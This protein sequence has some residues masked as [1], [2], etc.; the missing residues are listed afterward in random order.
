MNQQIER[1][2]I[3]IVDDEKSNIIEL[4]H[5]L[6]DDYETYIV[7]D[8][9]E[10]ME[11]AEQVMPDVILLDILMPE[12]DGY[13][14]L[15]KLKESEKTNNI[16][17][18]F[19]TGLNSA[20]AE[21]KG[22]SLGAADYITKPFHNAIVKMRIKNQMKIIERYAIE[23]HEKM[24]QAVND[25]ANHL[26]Q[27]GGSDDVLPSLMKG[28]EV[29]CKSMNAD[30]FNIWRT[31]MKDG[32]L[33]YHREYSWFS[34][35][36]SKPGETPDVLIN[37]TGEDNLDWGERFARDETISGIISEM[38][39]NDKKFLSV[40]G[41]KSV[42]ICPLFLHGKFWGI[43]SLDDCTNERSFRENEINVLKSIS[44]MMVSAL[45][46][47]A[48]S[49]GVANT[50]STMESILDSIGVAIYATVPDTGELLFV[51][52]YMKNAFGIVGDEA[53]GKH[54]YEVFRQGYDKMCDFCPCYQL[55]E[56]PDATIVWDEYIPA[57]DAH[58]RHSDC[59]INWYD[60]RKVHMQYA[61]D[62]TQLTKS[63]EEA[64]AASKAKSEFL[65]NMSHEIRTP[66]NAIFGMT[67]IG[68]KAKDIDKKDFSF[69]KI[70][71]ASSHLLGIINDI[72]DIAKIEA[73][74]MEIATVEFDFKDM[75]NKIL[76]VTNVSSDEKKQIVTVNVDEKI[77]AAVIG[78]DKRLTQVITNLLSNAIKFTDEG[79]KIGLNVSIEGNTEKYCELRVEVTD[80][81]I[82][83]SPE[84]LEKLFDAFEQAES[85][86]TRVYGGTGLGLAISKSIVEA[87]GGQIWAESDLG[88]GTKF[89]FIIRVAHSMAHSADEA[90]SQAEESKAEDNNAAE[91]QNAT[92]EGKRLLIVEDMASNRFVLISLLE[93]SGLIIDCAVNGKEALDMFTAD[94]DKYDIIFMDIR[95]P[96]MDGHEATRKIRA[97]DVPKAKKIPIIAVTANVFTEDIK[98]CLEAGMDG[99]LRKPVEIDGVMEVLEKYLLNS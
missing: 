57:M 58:V 82:G 89:T 15:A 71:E 96:I 59:Y 35:E 31:E 78:D 60:G 53:I 3:L 83:I 69:D 72:L 34:E 45:D 49:K 64:Q 47:H 2:K 19:I 14:V 5:I 30:R 33:H 55:N 27:L 18:I 67:A 80:S 39:A 66:M 99:H 23:K 50:L 40:L 91:V 88:S 20:D 43:F 26:F 11:T 87:M 46:R 95:M 94:P 48:L 85:G 42:I 22:L 10:T 12:M 41:I 75:I 54:C 8:S 29:I 32:R 81:G 98:K 62:I 38:P 37:P 86:T 16:P 24:L 1:N 68:K 79:G 17:V 56:N 51:N 61:V 76:T 73:N 77:P 4:T 25:T 70:E 84:N 28:M 90:P 97:L 74:K 44:L 65:A 21:E 63:R 9:R 93:D 13:E 7:R 36:G 52:S 6:G 92:L